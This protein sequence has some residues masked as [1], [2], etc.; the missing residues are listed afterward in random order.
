MNYD[1]NRFVNLTILL[2]AQVDSEKLFEVILREAMLIGHCDGGTI[3]LKEDN[4]LHFKHVITRSKNVSFNPSTGPEPFPP[5]PMSKAYVCAYSAMHRTRLNIP[6]V[7]RSTQFDFMGTR[8]Y[9]MRNGYRTSSMLVIPMAVE[10]DEVIG[11][12]QLINATDDKGNIAPFTEEQ[13]H[14]VMAL[15]SV[16]ALYIENRQLKGLL[17]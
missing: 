8:Q 5:V 10:S 2:S 4:E 14:L 17:R 13:E 11:V 1:L 3:Y 16:A 12:L 6:D 9:D 7:Y 15:G